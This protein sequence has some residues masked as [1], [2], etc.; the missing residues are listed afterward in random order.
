MKLL[1]PIMLLAF[2]TIFS[3]SLFAQ[4]SGFPTTP[5][6]GRGTEGYFQIVKVTPNRNANGI[7]STSNVY[8]Y[9]E[10]ELA[11]RDFVL[12]L[13]IDDTDAENDVQ[14][15][16]QRGPGTKWVSGS[17]TV[18]HFTQGPPGTIFA[19][20]F[21]EIK[22]NSWNGTFTPDNV[23]LETFKFPVVPQGLKATSVLLDWQEPYFR[24][25]YENN[26]LNSVV[27]DTYA[28][29]KEGCEHLPAFEDGPVL[30]GSTTLPADCSG[31][32]FES[33]PDGV[34]LFTLILNAEIRTEIRDESDD[35]G[36]GTDGNMG[37]DR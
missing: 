13:Y 15:N 32:T 9:A 29:P 1:S 26:K 25:F 35:G 27:V 23:K 6:D 36:S 22:L 2:C 17:K 7:A 30:L 8:A 21:V 10:G 12:E 16:T 20:W 3:S 4:G 5:D 18:E 33:L 34:N 37:T 11:N 19:K 31:I 28:H 14:V 24:V